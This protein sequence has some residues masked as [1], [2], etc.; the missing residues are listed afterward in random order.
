MHWKQVEY[1]MD[2]DSILG[3][4]D[5]LD[6]NVL[7]GERRAYRTFFLTRELCSLLPKCSHSMLQRV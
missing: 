5:F 3:L 1:I 6:R 7:I 4:F 2:I